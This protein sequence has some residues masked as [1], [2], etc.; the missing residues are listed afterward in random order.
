[1]KN[2]YRQF[3]NPPKPSSPHRKR[4]SFKREVNPRSEKTEDIRKLESPVKGEIRPAWEVYFHARER[5]GKPVMSYQMSASP[6]DFGFFIAHWICDA[7]E[8]LGYDPNKM[9]DAIKR[10]VAEGVAKYEAEVKRKNA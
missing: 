4:V 9:A 5:R 2:D 6:V 8:K 10:A 3:F 7:A 1:M